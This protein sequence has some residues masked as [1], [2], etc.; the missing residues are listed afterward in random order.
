VAIFFISAVLT[1]GPDVISQMILAIPSYLLFEV[2]L[3]LAR[4]VYP[5]TKIL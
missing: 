3:I 4:R 2:S 1:P 5:K